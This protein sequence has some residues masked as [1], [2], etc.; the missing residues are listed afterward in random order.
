M[1]RPQVPAYGMV[2]SYQSNLHPDSISFP[3][4]A[5]GATATDLQF[6]N[7]ALLKGI[8]S[9]SQKTHTLR[10]LQA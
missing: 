3:M 2:E 10:V 6:P 4:R 1:H 8:L 9:K 5:V 7:R